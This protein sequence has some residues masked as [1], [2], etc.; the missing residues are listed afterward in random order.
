MHGPEGTWRVLPNGNTPQLPEPEG[1]WAWNP[2]LGEYGEMERKG[3]GPF[4]VER[5]KEFGPVFTWKLGPEKVVAIMDYEIIRTLLKL[6]ESKTVVGWNPEAMYAMLG[7]SARRSLENPAFRKSSRK[8]LAP[9]FSREALRHYMSKLVDICRTQLDAWSAAPGPI[10]LAKKGKDLSFE[11]STQL[12]VDFQVPSERKAEV[13]DKFNKL[14]VGMVA[15]PIR[16]PGTRFSQGLAARAQLIEDIKSLI[17]TRQKGPRK[18]VLDYM[19]DSKAE[20]QG[21]LN[22]D[23]VAESGM[24]LIIAGNDTSGLGVTALLAVL[25]MFPDVLQ[26]MRQE[27]EQLIQQHGEELTVGVLDE[28]HYTEAVIKEV[29]RVAPPSGLVMRKTQ[30]DMEIGGKFVPAGS[31]LHLSTFLGQ[32][33]TDPSLDVCSY[34]D[35]DLQNLYD[36]WALITQHTDRKSTL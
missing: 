2:L 25:P 6:G 3:M 16:L 29:L 33:M 36:N 32:V 15:P 27:Q 22:D 31:I 13:R 30:V 26:K 11:F 19:L 14:F 1:R 34:S 18:S 24:G 17:A 4:L 23:E 7:E 20:M 28:M 35:D 8:H 5:Y 10:D 9:G 12:L 21:A